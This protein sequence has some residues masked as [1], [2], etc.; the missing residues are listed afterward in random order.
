MSLVGATDFTLN[1]AQAMQALGGDAVSKML[2]RFDAL[3]A[4][5]AD[6]GL[7][8]QDNI[9]LFEEELVIATR[10]GNIGRLSEKQQ[11]SLATSMTKLI[12]TQIAY[13]GALGESVDVVRTFTLSLLNNASDFQSR[14]LLTNE[15]TR[16]EMLKGAQEFVSVLRA[17]G[18]TLGGELAAAA[19]EAASFGA[20]GFSDSAKRFITVLP[21][22]SW[23]F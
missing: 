11:Q 5:G 23:F 1:T 6:F 9:K 20:I 16:Q 15:A 10:L 17:T 7:T 14:L 3:N 4:S 22:L 12:E 19:L 2:G 21:G 18:G 13:S 8:L